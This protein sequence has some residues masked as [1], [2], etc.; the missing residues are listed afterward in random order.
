M[1]RF[2]ALITAV[3]AIM[4][5]AF[6]AATGSQMAGAA[7]QPLPGMCNGRSDPNLVIIAHANGRPR[8]VPKFIL[9]VATDATGKPTG[10]LILDRGRARITVSDFC[11]VWQHQ[12][13]QSPGGDCETTYPTG[14]ITA[15]AVGLTRLDGQTLL[16]RT[17]VRKMLDGSMLFRARYRTWSGAEIS[18]AA[19][20]GG[21]DETGWTWI[22]AEEAWSPLV[23]MSVRASA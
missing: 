3:I 18:A 22:P 20:T 14:A 15:H 16:V 2:V 1:K 12:P 17:D 13:D 6:L 5:M 21:C 23:Q 9:N 11:R 19:D 7:A 8:D 10:S 4:F